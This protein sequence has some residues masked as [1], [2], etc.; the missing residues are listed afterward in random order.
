MA[1]KMN[2]WTTKETTLKCDDE[3]LRLQR[4]RRLADALN[5]DPDTHTDDHI[6]YSDTT[7]RLFKEDPTWA[8]TQE[9]E[10]R[11][12]AAAAEEKRLR[13]KPMPS[14]KRAFLHGLAED[15][16]LDSESQD[17]EPHR[18][19]CIFKTPK[20]VSAPQ[21]TLAQCM[22]ILRAAAASAAASSAR[23]S[24]TMAERLPPIQAFNAYLLKDPQFGLTIDELDQS[25]VAALAAVT[26]SGPAIKFTT[27]FLPS[28]EIVIKATPA[29][30]AAATATS[31]SVTPQSVEAAL[32]AAKPALTT[33]ISRTGLAS[34]VL[35]CHVDSSLNI[36]RREGTVA[37]ASAGGWNA[38][39]S[40]GSWRKTAQSQSPIAPAP[41]S[42][43]ALKRV[44]LK[45]SEKEK[46]PVEDDWL[47]AAEESEGVEGGGH[48]R[49]S[50]ESNGAGGPSPQA[51]DG[52]AL[53]GGP[54]E[55]EL[56]ASV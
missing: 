35:L 10:F 9:R 11:I 43:L 46:E 24:T 50:S 25:L 40:R 1:T 49:H 44:S 37:S 19:V 32:L 14:N 12:F 13:F 51:G 52:D 6:P 5:I 33:T 4:N 42:F 26:R 38:V 2:P 17:P 56:A 34:A 53:E 29:G 3:C 15:F 55:P 39:A 31:L 20:F 47:A 22:R 48:D 54:T 18:H 23:Q 27:S 41:R 36:T 16:G 21:K 30:T 45:K 8:Q 7:L 28:D